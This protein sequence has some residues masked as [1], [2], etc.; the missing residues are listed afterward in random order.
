MK[1]SIEKEALEGIVR[2]GMKAAFSKSNLPEKHQEDMIKSRLKWIEEELT[3]VHP[4]NTSTETS[5]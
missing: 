5:Q 4:K 1:I 3:P 2:E